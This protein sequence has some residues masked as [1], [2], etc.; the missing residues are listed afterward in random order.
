MGVHKK[1]CAGNTILKINHYPK[2]NA[3]LPHPHPLPGG[4]GAIDGGSAPLPPCG[5]RPH[6]F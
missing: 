3:A 6:I 5:L 4:E 2:Y 1:Q